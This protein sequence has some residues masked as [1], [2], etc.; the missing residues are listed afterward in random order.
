MAWRPWRK[1]TSAH[2]SQQ[3]STVGIARP[4]TNPQTAAA[5]TAAMGTA[6]PRLTDVRATRRES[7]RG[8]TMTAITAAT[9]SA[10]TAAAHASGRRVDAGGARAPTPTTA[11]HAGTRAVS[12]HPGSC[13][14]VVPSG[15]WRRQRSPRGHQVRSSD[16]VAPAMPWSGRQKPSRRRSSTSVVRAKARA[17]RTTRTAA[18]DAGRRSRRSKAR[19]GAAS[20]APGTAGSLPRDAAVESRRPRRRPSTAPGRGRLV[21]W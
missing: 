1:M 16:Q 10:G 19:R 8:P 6:K 3:P 15:R 11:S 2:A 4:R 14:R 17:P 7:D 9:G 21:W 13:T 20:G 12:H 18:A 5:V